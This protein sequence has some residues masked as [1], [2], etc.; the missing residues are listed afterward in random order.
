MSLLTRI[1][2]I[3]KIE[4]KLMKQSEVALFI[5]IFSKTTLLPDFTLTHLCKPHE[6]KSIDVKSNKA[7]NTDEE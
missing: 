1:L 5:N 7:M 3:V 2:N 4:L 6:S